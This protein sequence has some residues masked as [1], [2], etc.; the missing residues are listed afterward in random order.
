MQ[1]YEKLGAFYLGCGYDL[2]RKQRRDNLLLYDSKD[3]VT[4]AVCVG[5]TGSGKTGLCIGLLEEAAI[6]GIPAIVIDPKGDLANLLLTFPELQPAD[7]RPWINEDDA[8]NQGLAPDALAAQQAEQW[9][10]GL[11]DWGQDGARIGKLRDSADMAIYTPGSNAGLAVS[12]MKSFAAPEAAF[13]D[14]RELFRDRVAGTVSSLLGLAGIDADPIQS[15]EHILLSTIVNAAWEKG[16]DLDLAGIIRQIQAPPF[17]RVGVMD[18]DSFYPAKDRFW[19]AMA[20]NNLIASP[21]FEAWLEGEPLDIGQLLHTAQGKP[22]ISIF[23]VAHLSDA[24]RMFFVSLLLNQTLAWVR[25]QSGTTSLRA[26]LYMDEIFG[27]FPPV[28]NPPSKRPLLT[29]LKQARAFGLGV[30]L[31]TQNPVDLDYKG[32]ANT[33]TWFIGRLQTERDKARLLDGLQSAAGE[34]GGKFDRGR[35]ERALSGLGSRVFLMNNVHEDAPEV[36]ESR[37]TLS[38]LR[39]PLARNQIQSLMAGRKTAAA[40]VPAV[41]SPKATA[42][43]TRPVLP[44][45]IPQYFVPLRGVLGSV[46]SYQPV[47]LGIAQTHFIDAK[48]GV[49]E[50]RDVI[51]TTLVGGEAVAVNWDDAT[52]L[53]IAPDDLE[54]APEAGAGFAELP[55]AAASPKNYAGWTREF[56]SWLFR[57]QKLDLFRCASLDQL[58]KPGESERDFRVRL[59]QAAREERDRRAE[60]LKKSYAPKLAALAERKRKAEQAVEREKGQ[61]KQQT[62]QTAVTVGT[63]L[64]GAFL[65]RKTLSMATLNRA[66]TVARA[67]GHSRKEAADVERAGETVDA[68]QSQIDGLNSQFKAEVDG[69]QSKIDPSSE[70]LETVTVR[71]KKANITVRLV[72]LGWM[73]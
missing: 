13:R 7:F 41:S 59:Q 51:A 46:V 30:V 54:K 48:T 10:Q 37:W 26:I 33:G 25:A 15:R 9:R 50:K 60:E 29:L 12:V 1:D 39:G 8:R 24:E 21:G 66:G 52:E 31:A 49:D 17:A 65:G 16:E 27:Y 42:A 23:S 58:S 62:L 47:L 73:A 38:Y 36:F 71:P 69:L 43:S 28:A 32:L 3:L 45:E 19:L 2:E 53:D 55:S 4:H 68:V 70:P 6:D 72:A 56:S 67:A 20:L 63:E 44:P 34:L 5:M 11:A 57:M 61:A 14:D 40:A 18:L 64:L 22:R 35:M